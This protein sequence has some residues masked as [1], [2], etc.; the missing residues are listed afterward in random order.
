MKRNQLAAVVL[1][2]AVAATTFTVTRTL[3]AQA[4]GTPLTGRFACVDVV[5]AFNE[6]Q[7]QKDLAGE[8]ADLQQKLQDE[9]ISRRNK[10]DAAQAELDKLDRE[11]PTYPER[12]RAFL[13]M[14][15]DYKNWAELKQADMSREIG[16][17][18]VKIYRDI[19][20]AAGEVAKRDGYDLV[21]YKGEFEQTSPDPD[22]IRE[23]IRSLQ[24]LYSNPS[25]DITQALVD[26]LNNDYRTQPRAKMMMVP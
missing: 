4:P 2:V 12:M 10:I 15:I 17:W 16:V 11:D 22:A 19:Q 7:R 20:K 5:K 1:T 9:N 26:K 23:Q 14:Q 3:H 13:A 6:Y 8:M 25:I 18:T 24:I 21:L